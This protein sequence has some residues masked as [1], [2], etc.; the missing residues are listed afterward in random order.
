MHADKIPKN[1]H[2]AGRSAVKKR[3]TPPKLEKFGNASKLT[4]GG[5]ASTR[6]D[7]GNNHMRPGS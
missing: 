4:A 2:Q 6:S 3:Y 1:N 7:S 5:V